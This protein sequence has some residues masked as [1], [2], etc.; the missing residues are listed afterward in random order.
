MTDVAVPIFVFG[1]RLDVFAAVEDVGHCFEPA[2][3]S[4]DAAAFDP[5]GNVLTVDSR[6]WP[7]RVTPADPPVNRRDEFVHRLRRELLF[8]AVAHPDRLDKWRVKHMTGE[9]LVECAAETHKYVPAGG[10]G[11]FWGC[12]GSLLL[13]PAMLLFLIVAIGDAT[14]AAPVRWV[15][16]KR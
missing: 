3:L 5:L 4:A 8:Y 15:R 10:P 2:D 12:V 1:D 6:G 11:T 7:V 16:G 9:Q 14:V 13:L